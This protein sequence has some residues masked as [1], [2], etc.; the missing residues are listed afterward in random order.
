MRF[1]ETRLTGAFIIEPELHEDARGFFARTF[2][3]QEFRE[4]GLETRFVQCSISRSRARG[5]L[6]GMHFQLPPAA[7]AK[8][9]R[10]TSG[11]VC[12]V[13]VDLRAESPTYLQHMSVELSARNLR[14][15]YVPQLFAHGFQTLEDET[16]VF[17]QISEFYAP[18]HATGLRFDD[19]ALKITWPLAVSVISEKDRR[20]PLLGSHT[21]EPLPKL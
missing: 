18:A 7:E 4:H 13:I 16:E 5:T 11:A 14:W 6:R 9:L 17:Y 19:P 2:C 12:D 3:A 15:F 20:W 10:C 21:A 8:L 1:I